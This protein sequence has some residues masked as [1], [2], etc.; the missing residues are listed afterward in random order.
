MVY[1]EHKID[2]IKDP[3][4]LITTVARLNEFWGNKKVDE[5]IGHNCR[6]YA[7][8]G[9]QSTA[10]RDLAYLSAAI[11]LY[12]K[13]YSLDVIPQVSLPP[14]EAPRE[15]YLTRSQAAQLLK[16]AYRSG[17]RHLVRFILIGLYSASRSGVILDLQ[18]HPNTVGGY[19]DLDKCVIHREAP[20]KLKTNKRKPPVVIT[21]RLLFWLKR[22]KAQDTAND[23]TTRHIVMFRGKP[24]KSIKK[25]W[26]ASRDASNTPKWAVPHIL[27]HTSVTWAMQSGRNIHL[28]SQYAGMTIDVLERTYWHHHPDFQSDMKDMF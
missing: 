5:I 16:Q 17:N 25:A 13:E 1:V 18:W 3:A 7:K 4:D 12:A 19:V 26:N 21:N 6:E 22:W 8:L 10:R 2:N 23:A 15:N 24:L 27:R 11:N 9:S 20:R 14:K 28:V